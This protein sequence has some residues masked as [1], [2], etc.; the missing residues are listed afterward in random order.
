MTIFVY[1]AT[2]QGPSLIQKI[3]E[4]EAEVRSV[5]C[6]DH[7]ADRL[8]ITERYHDFVKKGT[9]LIHRDFGHGAFRVDVSE[10]ITAGNSWQLGFYLAH[11]MQAQGLLLHASSANNE[12]P[13]TGDVVIW[14]TG[15]VKSDRQITS[16]DKILQKLQ[17]SQELFE[18][19]RSKQIQ[20]L[21]F[22]PF[23]DQG[24][25]AADMLSALAIESEVTVLKPVAQLKEALH[26]IQCRV[27]EVEQAAA[28]SGEPAAAPKESESPATVTR[29]DTAQVKKSRLVLPLIGIVML[30]IIAG[31]LWVKMDSKLPAGAKPAPNAIDDFGGKPAP[32]FNDSSFK[33][34]DSLTDTVTAVGNSL[35]I[36]ADAVKVAV[37]KTADAMAT[38]VDNALGHTPA[39]DIEVQLTNTGSPCIN[40]DARR[41]ILSPVDKQFPSLSMAEL[42]GL[43]IQGNDLAGTVFAIELT[44]VEL[45]PLEKT[46]IGWRMPLPRNR[47][48]DHDVAF[49]VAD[50]SQSLTLQKHLVEQLR[51]HRF[52]DGSRLS[53]KQLGDWFKEDAPKISFYQQSF[54]VE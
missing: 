49:V 8:P 38:S 39:I 1:I 34:R 24:Q 30:L 36:A 40:G 6:L 47:T 18:H 27:P 37:A 17:L 46:A 7:T 15:E 3:T 31:L 14:A 4:E 21:I 42:C 23:A 50:S 35:T 33:V 54:T 16:V 48:Q 13:Q 25:C 44:F 2:T 26:E 10:P 45:I 52:K 9:G 19:C 28:A 41:K 53:V 51:A 29:P 20:T 43:L 12:T 5:V 32:G 22:Y 11:A